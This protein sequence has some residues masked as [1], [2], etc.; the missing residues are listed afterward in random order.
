MALPISKSVP[1]RFINRAALSVAALATGAIVWFGLVKLQVFL[2][3]GD[4]H[5]GS[6][7]SARPLRTPDKTVVM[8]A[9][10]FYYHQTG[11]FLTALLPKFFS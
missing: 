4:K 11:D 5:R 7:I 3:H 6:G 9:Q 2:T 8:G 10:N 1:V